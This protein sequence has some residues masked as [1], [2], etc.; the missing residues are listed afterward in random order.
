VKIQFESSTAC[1]AKCTFCPRYDMTRPRGE[2]SDKLFHK[3]IKD[4]QAMRNSFF[5][6]F[7]NGEPFV[8]PRIWEWLDYL[9][10]AQARV[11]IYTNAEYVDVGKLVS[12]PNISLICCSV[13]AATKTT[14]DSIMRGPDYNV[15]TNN[16]RELIKRAKCK[17]FS[18]MVIVD[19]N[20]HETDLF[21][22]TWGDHTVFGEFRNWT[23]DRHCTIER[24]GI[25]KPCWAV[26]NTMSI[27]WDGRVVPCCMDYDGKLILGDVNRHTLTE[28]WHQSYWIRKKSRRL[29]F[30]IEPCANCNYNVF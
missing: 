18:S 24:T 13:N 11:H 21:R 28:I 10:A 26:L 9:A 5:V 25:R 8:F 6:P 1:N 7:L 2:M 30:N 23:G 27:L 20:Q 19:E 14:Y 17:V 29:E 16:V 22:T 4:G 15:V 3:I 12:Y